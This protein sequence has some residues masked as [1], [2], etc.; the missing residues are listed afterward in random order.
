MVSSSKNLGTDIKALLSTLW[1]FVLFNMLFRDLHD[2]VRPGLLEEMM[3]GV[4]NGTQITDELLLVGGIMVEIPIAMVLL[5]RILKYGL[6]Q[7]Q[8]LI[9]SATS[10]HTKQLLIKQ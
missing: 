6:N 8:L 1:I 2:F 10:K 7:Q 3:A 5:S 4:V 9:I